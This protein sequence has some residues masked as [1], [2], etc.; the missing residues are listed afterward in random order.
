MNAFIRL[1]TFLCLVI[2]IAGSVATASAEALLDKV[3]SI[4]VKRAPLQKTLE[5]ISRKG[6]FYF[7]YNSSIIKSD[8]IVSINLNN[9]PVK[10]VLNTLL[11]KNYEF[12][13]TGNYIIIKK[14]VVHG[15]V[16]NT[17]TVTQNDY[18]VISGYVVDDRT[19]QKIGNASVYEK[20]RLVSTLTNDSG[21]FSLKLY[22]KYPTAAITV[23]KEYYDDTTITVQPKYNQ[24]ITINI[25]R[26]DTLPEITT[27]SPV[28]VNLPAMDSMTAGASVDTATLIYTT[29]K[30][31][32][33]WL[34]RTGLGRFFLSS[35][36]KIQSLNIGKF[37]AE[38]PYQISV[39]P[40][41]STH[42]KLSGQVVNDVSLNI[43]GGYNAGVNGAELG[44]LFNI[45]RYDVKH[46]QLAG[47][48]N[49]TNG[50]VAGVQVA[51]VHNI[52]QHNV[53]GLQ[54]TGVTNII[55]GSLT[56]VQVAGV[57]N[58]SE[59]NTK[60]VQVAGIANYTHL[61]TKG[62]QVAGI[63]NIS[64]KDMD[65]IQA[66]GI[67]NYTKKLHGIQVG[68][69]NIAGSSDGYSIGLIN[70]VA[71]GYHK[72]SVSTNEVMNTNIA[73][74][75]GTHKLYSILLGGMNIN[76]SEKLY[77]FGYGLGT[78][79]R[80]TNFLT[81]NPEISSQ[82]LYRGSWKYT[83]LLNKL[84]PQLNIKLF[85]PITLF[86]GPVFNVYY[87]NQTTAFT[88]YKSNISP[89]GYH[90]YDLHNDRLKSWID[91]NVGISV[92]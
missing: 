26:A 70:F 46:A 90:L 33:S 49:I 71:K 68:L 11:N 36:Q 82:Y 58:H 2:M 32:S 35:A 27:I 53:T 7:S 28:P 34:K 29:K 55:R 16:I 66:A 39:I 76:D 80:L 20:E 42:G 30:I 15:V 21:Y 38:R 87:S 72:I 60:G 92:F 86:G 47:I 79:I 67:F 83:N 17:K 9:S 51:G 18:Y 41:V 73:F 81:L 64:N 1:K 91:W 74:K 37:I 65:G 24:E 50:S 61:A 43:L 69:I 88:G 89:T 63:A 84:S 75:T 22:S 78:E 23:S 54:V 5:L 57:Y 12:T 59:N 85:R 52:V 14:A 31:D 48:F 44:I 45:N 56:G 6:E 77:S 19:G 13:E 4:E 8:S 40:G 62:I 10:H 25:V 3:I